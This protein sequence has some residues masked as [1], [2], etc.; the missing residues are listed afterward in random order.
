[1][2][3]GTSLSTW[4]ITLN[5]WGWGFALRTEIIFSTYLCFTY[6]NMEALRCLEFITGYRLSCLPSSLVCPLMYSLKNFWSRIKSPGSIIRMTTNSNI[7]HFCYVPD[8]N[9]EVILFN[10]TNLWNRCFKHPVLTEEECVAHHRRWVCSSCRIPTA[11]YTLGAWYVFVEWKAQDYCGTQVGWLVGSLSETLHYNATACLCLTLT[12]YDLYSV[13]LLICCLLF[14]PTQHNC[15][16]FFFFF[17]S[18]IHMCIH[19]VISSPCPL[20]LLSSSLPHSVPGRSC[21]ALITNFVEEK[22]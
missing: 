21:S 15:M 2:W 16:N 6:K 4:P 3:S 11:Q 7:D 12:N 14:P 5:F 18:F 1:M 19:W 22:T 20:P 13:S 9:A 10:L 8:L 17:Y